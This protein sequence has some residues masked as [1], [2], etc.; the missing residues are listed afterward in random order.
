MKKELI[1]FARETVLKN[2]DKTLKVP[3]EKALLY[4][5]NHELPLTWNKVELFG[6][7][8][9]SDFIDDKVRLNIHVVAISTG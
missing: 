3:M 2:E 6:P 5:D 9:E 7:D 1:P 4:I 8:Y